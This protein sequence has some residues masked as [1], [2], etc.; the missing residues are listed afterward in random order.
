MKELGMITVWLPGDKDE[1]KLDKTIINKRRNEPELFYIYI[2]V[3][4]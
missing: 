2:I 1:M 4:K 3:S